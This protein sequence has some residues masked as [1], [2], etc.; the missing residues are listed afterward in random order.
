MLIRVLVSV[1]IIM[2]RL[3]TKKTNQL[4]VHNASQILS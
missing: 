4:E 1:D 2:K 3:A